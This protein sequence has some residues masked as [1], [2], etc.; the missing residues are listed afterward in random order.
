MK[1]EPVLG[2]DATDARQ[3]L[4]VPAAATALVDGIFHGHE[5]CPGQVRI[6]AT[7]DGVLHLLGA[8]AAAL[9]AEQPHGGAAVRGDT[10]ALVQVDVSELMADDLIARAHVYLDADLIGH[11]AGRAEKR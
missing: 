4:Q 9:P 7:I 5:P 1:R 6:V 3:L 10:A 8:E 11:G 2:A